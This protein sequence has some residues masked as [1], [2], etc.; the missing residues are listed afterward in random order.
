MKTNF[1]SPDAATGTTTAFNELK[2]NRTMNVARPTFSNGECDFIRGKTFYINKYSAIYVQDVCEQQNSTLFEQGIKLIESKVTPKRRSYL[3]KMLTLILPTSDMSMDDMAAR[4]R[5]V[6]PIIAFVCDMALHKNKKLAH[7]VAYDRD[8]NKYVA[9]LFCE[10]NLDGAYRQ[11]IY[12]A[13][14]IT[15][16]PEFLTKPEK[17]NFVTKTA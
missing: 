16:V 8:F 14:E 4:S 13:Q 12:L 7:P 11:Y 17:Y 9:N 10:Y 5:D 1:V 6:L 3:I 2:I 15:P